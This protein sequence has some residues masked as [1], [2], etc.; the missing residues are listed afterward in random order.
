MK[1]STCLFALLIRIGRGYRSPA[2]FFQLQLLLCKCRRGARRCLP[3]M[4]GIERQLARGGRE[5]YMRGMR[6]IAHRG[7]FVP[8]LTC[9]PKPLNPPNRLQRSPPRKHLRRQ[10]S[11]STKDGCR[12]RPKSPSRGDLG[13]ITPSNAF[14]SRLSIAESTFEQEL[15][16][17]ITPKTNQ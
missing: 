14:G 7:P 4:F 15:K 6:Q 12:K 3:Y 5:V 8:R 1:L 10:A 17:R 16:L 2:S 9:R 11:W 13:L